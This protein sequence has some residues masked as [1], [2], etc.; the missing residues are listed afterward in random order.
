VAANLAG[1]LDNAADSHDGFFY[2]LLEKRYA[3]V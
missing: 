2:A 3:D 1:L